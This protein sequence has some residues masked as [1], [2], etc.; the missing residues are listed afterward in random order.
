MY[1]G[2]ILLLPYL[3]HLMVGL[4]HDGRNLDLRTRLHTPDTPTPG[5]RRIHWLLSYLKR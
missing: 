1:I 2:V 5:L 3:Q 4:V